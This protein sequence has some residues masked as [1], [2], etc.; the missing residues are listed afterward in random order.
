MQLFTFISRVAIQPAVWSEKLWE[1]IRGIIKACRFRLGG[2]FRIATI[3][4]RPSSATLHIIYSL[5]KCK[6]AFGTTR[7]WYENKH[8]WNGRITLVFAEVRHGRFNVIK[9]RFNIIKTCKVSKSWAL[10]LCA[11]REVFQE[12]C[13][14]RQYM[15]LCVYLVVCFLWV[16]A[17]EFPDLFVSWL[18]WLWTNFT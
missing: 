18:F 15:R 17:C 16:C 2:D 5:Q 12:S 14:C 8:P 1:Q 9:K 11:A 7:T 13:A 3:R 10:Q 4:A 6:A